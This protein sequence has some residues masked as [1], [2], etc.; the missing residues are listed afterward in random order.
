[1]VI[2]S[3][4]LLA[5]FYDEPEGEEIKKKVESAPRLIV[6]SVTLVESS[7]AVLRKLGEQSVTEFAA[8]IEALHLEVVAFDMEQARLA[9]EAYVRYGKGR[10]AARLNL[11][12]CMV[13]ALAKRLGEP[14]L[15]KGEDFSLTD[16][17]TGK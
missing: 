9:V 3:S 4:A 7:V 11:G 15:F 17:S 6:S 8:M 14:L 5:L 13:Y 1:M 16:I 10:H 2:D 12:D